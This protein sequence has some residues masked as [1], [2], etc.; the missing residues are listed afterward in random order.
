MP[1]S[2]NSSFVF[3]GGEFTASI[4]DERSLVEHLGNLDSQNQVKVGPIGQF[5]YDNGGFHFLTTPDRVSISSTF[6]RS[7]LSK[8]GPNGSKPDIRM[9]PAIIPEKLLAATKTVSQLLDQRGT[10]QVS[11]VGI[12]CETVFDRQEINQSGIEFCDLNLINPKS[13]DLI[14]T[15][16]V[17]SSSSRFIFERERIR[18]EVIIEP[19]S[20]SRGQNLFTAVNAHQ[21]VVEGESL[22]DKIAESVVD[23]VKDYL[24]EFHKKILIG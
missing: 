11:G 8:I 21:D 22:V 10:V 19:H 23:E 5:S 18:F 6:D 7:Y 15:E 9:N 14:G 2:I 17:V 16:S 13:K 24:A 20:A 12:N 1:E 3:A 4:F